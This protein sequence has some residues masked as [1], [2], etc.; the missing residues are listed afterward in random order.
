[1]GC[2]LEF[3][4]EFHREQAGSLGSSGYSLK[5]PRQRV[6]FT[7]TG[8]SV[9]VHTKFVKGKASRAPQKT[10]TKLLVALPSHQPSSSKEQFNLLMQ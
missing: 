8:R 2:F 3:C 10:A 6:Q 5:R 1:M 4:S 7:L 9:R